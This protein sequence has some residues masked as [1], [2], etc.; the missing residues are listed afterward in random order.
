MVYNFIL[1]FF[2]DLF[3]YLLDVRLTEDAGTRMTLLI[4]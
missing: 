2:V 1:T 3:V 4:H